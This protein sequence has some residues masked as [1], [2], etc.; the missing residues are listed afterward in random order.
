MPVGGLKKSG[1]NKWSGLAELANKWWCYPC[2]VIFLKVN[3]SQRLF[4]ET[5]SE[6]NEYCINTSGD[7]TVR[8][9]MMNW[10]F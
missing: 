9:H 8:L 4:D 2:S 7:K 6:L 10:L 1:K 5:I 3:M